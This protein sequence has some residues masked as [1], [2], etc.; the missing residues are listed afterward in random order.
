M[1]SAQQIKA[2]VES[3]L[4]D[5]DERFYTLALQVAAQE[6]RQGHVRVAAELKALVD[7]ARGK[8]R[9]GR[10]AVDPIPVVQPRGDLAGL[11]HVSYPKQ[12]LSDMVLADSTRA[13]LER[14][15][16][17]HREQH[18]L[19]E[20]GLLPRRKILLLGPP[21][22]GKTMTGASLAG[23]LHLP[24]F[25]TLLDGIITR[26]LGE[27]AVK[28]RLVFDGIEQTAGVY[29]FDEFDAIGGQRMAGNDVGEIRRV[30][31][32]FLQFL[33]NDESESLILAATNHPELLDR[34]LFRRFDD[35]I[36]YHLPEPERALQSMR[37]CLALFD[38]SKVDWSEA[39]KAAAGLSF[40]DTARACENAAK[41]AILAGDGS[42]D[43]NTL[44]RLLAER[45]HERA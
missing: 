33:E 35:V 15:V 25:S 12:R 40:A 8:T 39:V 11:L 37:N 22:T 29:F 43:T 21:G 10:R 16:Q 19:R 14:I 7:R 9:A 38:T 5:D 1:P 18:R 42:I 24:L 28:L 4:D 2:L 44:V 45:R 6:A 41:E 32:S 23:E 36:H 3:H 30:L 13:R 20:Y 27:T 31:N 17:E 34:A 26:Y